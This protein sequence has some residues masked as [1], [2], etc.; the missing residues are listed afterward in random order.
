MYVL[1]SQGE[2]RHIAGVFGRE[3]GKKQYT[4]QL[5]EAKELPLKSRRIAKY[6]T[7]IYWRSVYKAKA[8]RPNTG[9]HVSGSGH[10]WCRALIGVELFVLRRFSLPAQHYA[11]GQTFCKLCKV[12][13]PSPLVWR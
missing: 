6:N 11:G 5:I 10:T 7:W 9:E 8:I 12:S 13:P 4:H 2:E 3:S 1:R